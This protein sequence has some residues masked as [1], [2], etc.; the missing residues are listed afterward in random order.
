MI[1]GLNSNVSHDGVEYHVQTEDLGRQN[2]C[3]LTLVFRAG[4]II[5]R[6][7]VN[8]RDA[9]GEGAPE[10]RIKHFMD[11]Q[12]HRV[13]QSLQAGPPHG[14]AISQ[15]QA[16][17]PASAPSPAPSP[18]PPLAPPPVEQKLDQLIAEYLRRRSASKPR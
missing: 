15:P 10:A 3:I 7:K 13:I 9:L 8:Y 12:H 17:A 1:P 6:E 11:Q 2:P 14:D 5:A 16:E 4:A 18:A